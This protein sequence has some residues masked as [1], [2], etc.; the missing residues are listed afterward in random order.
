MLLF[1][2]PQGPLIEITDPSGA[3]RLRMVSDMAYA[4]GSK[5]NLSSPGF[6]IGLSSRLFNGKFLFAAFPFQDPMV[7][8]PKQES[9]KAYRSSFFV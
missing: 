6:L 2:V 5:P 8:S 1:P 7:L 9:E 4:N 3:S